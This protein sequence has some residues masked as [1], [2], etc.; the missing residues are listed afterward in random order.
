MSEKAKE[1]KI[2]FYHWSELASYIALI[3]GLGFQIGRIT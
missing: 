1:F 3:F 2:K